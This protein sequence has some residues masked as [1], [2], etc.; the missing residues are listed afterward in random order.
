MI[1]LITGSP[2]AGKTAWTVQEITRLPTQRKIYVHGIPDLKI[3][4]EPIY[5]RSVLCDLCQSV[6]DEQKEKVHF[7][8]DWPLWVTPGSLIIVDEVQRIWRPTNGA[9]ALSDGISRLE[10][11]RHEGLDFWLISQGPHLFH[12]NI[13]LLIGRHIHLV[14]SWRGR[15]EYE[16]P[17]CRQD[18]TRRSDAVVRPY[19]LP[20]KVFKLYTSASLHTKQSHRK[21]LSLYFFMFV[22]VLVSFMGYRVYARISDRGKVQE[23]IIKSNSPGEIISSPSTIQNNQYFPDFK[24][25]IENIPA[26]APAYAK[27]VE[28]TQVPHLI[29]CVKTPDFCRCYSRQAVPVALSQQFC[30]EFIAGHYFNPFR[31]AKKIDNNYDNY[32]QADNVNN[33][34]TTNNKVE[35]L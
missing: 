10:T 19:S 11:H 31:E 7:V 17:E 1:T 34:K 13:R 24:P 32:Q 3:A 27:L 22:M 23:E 6:T 14:A 30:T 9:S 26:S 20:K 18:V 25:A 33:F 8:E 15:S 21:P 4:H 12:S 29:G 2:G 35:K 16:F 28:V 5:C